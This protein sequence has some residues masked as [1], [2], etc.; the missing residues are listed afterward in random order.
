MCFT[1][2]FYFIPFLF[3]D[4]KDDMLSSLR[5]L[6]LLRKVF[7]IKHTHTISPPLRRPFTGGQLALSFVYFSTKTTYLL[8]LNREKS[9][10]TYSRCY[11]NNTLN[12]CYSDTWFIHLKSRRVVIFQ[13]H[14][15]ATPTSQNS[16]SRAPGVGFFTLIQG[17]S[18]ATYLTLPRLPRRPIGPEPFQVYIMAVH[19]GVEPAFQPWQGCDLADNRMNHMYATYFVVV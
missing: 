1:D 9:T 6:V 19:A 8:L 15:Y 7:T 10:Y 11:P 5:N 2:L 14:A 18:T 3:S 16:T 12:V 13:P 4:H 17:I